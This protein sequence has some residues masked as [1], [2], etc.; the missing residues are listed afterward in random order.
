MKANRLII[1]V[2]LSILFSNTVIAKPY[3]PILPTQFKIK[4]V[5]ITI[6]TQSSNKNSDSHHISLNGNGDSYFIKN[7]QKQPINIT[8]EMLIDLLNDFYAVHFFEISDTFNIKKN[9]IMKDDKTLTTLVSKE[10]TIE[11]KKVCVQLRHYKKCISVVD[12]QPFG[13]SQ[14]VNK[15][16]SLMDATSH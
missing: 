12:N 7:N 1:S 16:E 13:V 9:V 8:S 6:S 4:H 11:S 14:I 10:S 2:L 15:V 5:S 3:S